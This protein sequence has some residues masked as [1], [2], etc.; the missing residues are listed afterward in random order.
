MAAQ[1]LLTPLPEDMAAWVADNYAAGQSWVDLGTYADETGADQLFGYFYNVNV[2]SLV[3][4]N[5]ENFEDAGYEVPETME[6]L[7]ALSE[8]ID[9]GRRD[10]VVHRPRLGSGDRLARDRLGRGHHAAHPGPRGL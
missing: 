3:W 1:G 7:I 4:Y 8:Q 5:P 2:K 9:R 10:A 6:E